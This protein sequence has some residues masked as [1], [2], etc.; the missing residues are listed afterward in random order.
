MLEGIESRRGGVFFINQLDRL[1][2][3]EENEK[4]EIGVY[5]PS[6]R[7]YYQVRPFAIL[8]FKFVENSA[9]SAIL[10][11]NLGFDFIYP[12]SEWKCIALSNLGVQNLGVTIEGNLSEYVRLFGRISYERSGFFQSSV[13]DTKHATALFL[14]KSS[15]LLQ[16]GFSFNYPEIPRCTLHGCEVERKHKHNGKP[17]RGTSIF[18]TRDSQGRR[19]YNK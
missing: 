10:D 4:K 12:A 15:L 18:T 17:Y 8:G 9:F 11:T 16:F 1:E 13:F 14:E 19:L 7:K 3:V 2:Y 6:Q 5:V